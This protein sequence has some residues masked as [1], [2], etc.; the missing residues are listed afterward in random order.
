MFFSE[1]IKACED[2]AVKKSSIYPS[3]RQ[4]LETVR[5]LSVDGGAARGMVPTV[6]LAEMEEALG[7][8]ISETFD[9]VGGT[10]VGCVLTSGLTLP[11]DPDKPVELWKPKY[12]AS[13]FTE[14]FY[15][16]ADNLLRKRSIPF[17]SIYDVKSLENFVERRYGN[18]VFHQSIIPTVGVAV[19]VSGLK[20]VTF[21]SWGDDVYLSKDVVLASA[22]APVIFYPRTIS[23]INFNTPKA[24][25]NLVIDGGIGA[26]NPAPLLVRE[27]KKIYPNAKRF[28]VVSLGVGI[29]RTPF[30]QDLFNFS[31]TPGNVISRVVDFGINLMAM[32]SDECMEDLI[33]GHYTRLN[34]VIPS[35]NASITNS[36]KANLQ[37]LEK[38]T[39][40]YLDE[41]KGP[42]DEMIER[43][44]E[45]RD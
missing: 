11:E 4:D 19:E 23:P 9:L 2:E 36:S 29:V 1:N 5:I 33:I 6:M 10:S 38:S 25:K 27:A 37:A 40:E 21:C 16:E 41:N 7:K 8:P 18:S 20:P 35:A 15:S 39:R 45:S 42:F 31:L 26:N 43:L 22:A 12:R 17:G 32:V 14:I 13:E 30:Y 34:P 44:K 24:K 3:I 28:D